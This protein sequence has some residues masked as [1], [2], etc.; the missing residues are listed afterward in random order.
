MKRVRVVA[1]GMLIAL[2][3]AGCMPERLGAD[4]ESKSS[5]R[6]LPTPAAQAL[7]PAAQARTAPPKTSSSVR[8]Y[9]DG[10]SNDV[11]M[12]SVRATECIATAITNRSGAEDDASDRVRELI[13]WAAPQCQQEFDALVTSFDRAYGSGLGL[14]FLRV[15][16]RDLPE[17]LAGRFRSAQRTAS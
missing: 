2:V 7:P 11:A 10:S 14:T 15:Y 12:R 6:A 9:N 16:L 8:A 1:S 4:S 5:A 3:A 13:A 17:T